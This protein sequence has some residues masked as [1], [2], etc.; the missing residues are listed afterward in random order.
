M[1]NLKNKILNA[2][3][4]GKGTEDVLSDLS[5]YQTN[6][7]KNHSNPVVCSKD[8]NTILKDRKSVV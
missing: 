3:K 8:K 7:L 6:L 4:L 2:L 5:F 1:A